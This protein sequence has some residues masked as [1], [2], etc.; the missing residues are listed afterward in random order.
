M[1]NVIK[2]KHCYTC[3]LMVFQYN[4]VDFSNLTA[5]EASLELTKPCPSVRMLVQ[6]NPAS[7]SNLSRD[8]LPRFQN[9][10]YQH[11]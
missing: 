1:L 11:N 7:K 4:G 5:E 9:L 2:K 8:G 3:I 10:L 6:Y